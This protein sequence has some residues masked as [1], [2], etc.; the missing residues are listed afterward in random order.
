MNGMKNIAKHRKKPLGLQSW[1]IFF[2]DAR[3]NE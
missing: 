1:L 3:K 2:P